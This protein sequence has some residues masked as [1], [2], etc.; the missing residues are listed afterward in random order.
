MALDFDFR[1]GMAGFEIHA[2]NKEARTPTRVSTE[3]LACLHRNTK[4]KPRPYG[5]VFAQFVS[6]TPKLASFQEKQLLRV[7]AL[8]Y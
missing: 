1:A 4:L 5:R 7:N 2:S 6:T 3:A 8:N